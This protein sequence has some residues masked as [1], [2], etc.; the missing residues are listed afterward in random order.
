MANLSNI[1]NKFLVTTGGDVGINTTSPNARLHVNGTTFL[2][3]TFGNPNTDAAYRIKFYDNGGVYNDAGIGLDGSGG[4]SEKMWFN[5]YSGFYWNQGTQGIKMMLDGTGRLGIGTDL[6]SSLLTLNATS[7][8]ALQWQY[9]GGNYL[10]IEADSGGGSYY[11]AAGFYHR[12]FTSGLERMRIDSSGNIR[13][14][15]TAPN[16][17]NE[18][19]QLNFYNTS[20]SLNLAR[21]TGIRQAGGSNYGALIFSTTNS[22]TIAERMRIDSSGNVGIGTDS[23]G[24]KLQVNQTNNDI[25]Q[26]TLH[27]THLSTTTKTR[28]GNWANDSKFSSNYMQS[29]GTKTQDDATI[30]SWVQ[31]MGGSLDIFD[32]SRSPAG[33]TTLSSLIRIDSSGLV[34]IPAYADG[35]K[36]TITSSASSNHNIIEM[37]QLGADG[38]LDV[39]AAGG[40]I[41]THLSGYTGYASY[42]LSNVGIGTTSPQAILDT[43]S[44]NA[45]GLAI[46][47][48]Y[49]FVALNDV[50]GGNLFLG[51]QSNEAYLWNSGTNNLIFGNNNAER[52]RITSGGFT[53][54]KT[55]G[56]YFGGSYHEFLNNNNVS[57]DRVMVIGNTGGSA[58]NNTSSIALTVADNVNDR[59]FI[60]GNGNVVNLNNSYGGM[61]DV[62]LKENIIDATSKLDDLMK[63]KI[64]N[65][66]FI[67]DDKKQ[68]GVV[69]QELEDIFPNMIDESI[70][71]EYKQVTD[72]EGN[73]TEQNIDLGTTTKSVKYSVF[74]PMLIKSIQELKAEIDELKK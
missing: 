13:F 55:G 43:F 34:S 71:Y 27:N 54:A 59:L 64:R 6:P 68:I 14:T 24:T 51:T 48:S 66:N 16:S 2:E 22:G 29:G 56:N 19:T 65:Y 72:E 61:S 20:S 12:F 49:P 9:N 5:A 60:Y 8:G 38:F 18:I 73:T 4:G 67:G 63:V 37:G 30:S 1:N 15:G 52:M 57:G 32:I 70:D 44:S 33:S 41:V 26:L 53:K 31:S 62:K 21:I 50:D 36:F 39:S 35:N 42:F 40:G 69:A 23:P 3:G 74:V 58:T 45:R 10:R 7:G 46:S 17:G 28:I 25:Y 47:N 11:A